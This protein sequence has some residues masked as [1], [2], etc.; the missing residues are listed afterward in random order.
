MPE[1][2][3]AEEKSTKSVVNKKQKQMM[4]EEGYDHLRD[5][6]RIRKNKKKKD[7]TTLPVS[8]EV[9]KT[10]KVNKGPSAL[11]RVKADI[12]K[13]YGKDAIMKVK[14]ESTELL[15]M[16]MK[17]GPGGAPIKKKGFIDKSLN[18][19]KV[20]TPVKKIDTDT[21]VKTEE[22]KS[23]FSTPGLNKLKKFK[24]FKSNADRVFGRKSPDL[25]KVAE[26]FGGY[27]VEAPIDAE[28]NITAKK[29]EARRIRKKISKIEKGITGKNIDV[30]A[31]KRIL[32]AKTNKKAMKDA[33]TDQ[34]LDKINKKPIKGGSL[35]DVRTY[36]KTGDKL[37]DTT[38]TPPKIETGTYNYSKNKPKITGDVPS[39]Q[40]NI[41]TGG[42]DPL[43]TKRKSGGGRPRGS[44]TKIK[45]TPGQQR[46]DLG[47]YGRKARRRTPNP[48]RLERIKKA[49][50]IKNPTVVGK[51][52]GKIPLKL[53]S[54]KVVQTA[55][56]TGTKTAVKKAAAKGTGKLLAKRIPGVGAAISGAETFGRAASGDYV[57]AAISGAETIAN[58]I[59]GVQQTLGTGLAG[60][61]MA[62]DIRRASRTAGAIKK[63]IS[64]AKRARK[65]KKVSS[66]AANVGSRITTSGGKVKSFVKTP[67][68]IKKTLPKT[69]TAYSPP[70]SGKIRKAIFGKTKLGRGVRGA[71][72]GQEFLPGGGIGRRAI[73]GFV[74]GAK[75]SVDGGHVGRRTAG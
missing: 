22:A 51:T 72:V 39:G 52:G 45:T 58:L 62:R 67:R 17:F 13:R 60:L 74:G 6:G 70:A 9:K 75:K 57:G 2:E 41:L 42:E 14:K 23:L 18:K 73:K 61:G 49:I 43:K 31:E 64:T 7:T 65:V 34:L 40:G 20:N 68:K 3:G 30:D 56:K 16:G 44:R 25:T 11:E 27:I 21:D 26:A 10:Q 28:G 24:D 5:Q 46:L 37:V 59:P 66:T 19:L 29:G 48:K 54:K 50:N 53:G 38:P 15:E 69:D 36:Q 4:G 12:E 55:L 35:A 32:D 47:D 33:G 71:A 63:T 8:D 1:K